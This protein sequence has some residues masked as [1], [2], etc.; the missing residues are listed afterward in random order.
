MLKKYIGRPER[1]LDL[2]VM[3]RIEKH[4]RHIQSA[5]RKIVPE[6]HGVY[7]RIREL[8]E[9]LVCCLIGHVV[10]NALCVLCVPLDIFIRRHHIKQPAVFI[11]DHAL[12][13]FHARGQIFRIVRLFGKVGIM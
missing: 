3:I 12:Q 2:P 8:V 7:A 13:I 11:P 5:V 4:I 6:I 10:R 1:R 9:E